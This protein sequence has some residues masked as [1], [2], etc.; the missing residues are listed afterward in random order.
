MNKDMESEQEVKDEKDQS[1]LLQLLNSRRD[2]AE[3]FTS[4]EFIQQ[5]KRDIESYDAKMPGI[6]DILGKSS[7]NKL[8]QAL[9]YRY[10]YVIPMVFTNTEAA[11]ASLFDR[12]PDLII[13]ARGKDDYWIQ[14]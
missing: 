8:Q 14:E 6:S 9:N 12:L 13:K 2:R 5:V 7:S 1:S 11:K 10:D 4:D 3:K